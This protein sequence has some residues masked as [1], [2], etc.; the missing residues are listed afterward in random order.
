MALDIITLVI[1][2][3]PAFVG[4]IKRKKYGILYSLLMTLLLTILIAGFGNL[5]IYA[6]TK[7]A[8]LTDFAS[9][10]VIVTR[11]NL[12]LMEDIVIPMLANIF[13]DK[14]KYF[15]YFSALGIYIIL[16]VL[17]GIFKKKKKNKDK[18]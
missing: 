11:Y 17:G 1:V 16:I 18:E 4:I 5:A 7:F 10:V 6:A 15:L 8:G 13:D 3:F 9:Y 14:A 12:A 2:I